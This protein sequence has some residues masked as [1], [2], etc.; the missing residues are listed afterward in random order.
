MSSST[1]SS[2]RRGDPG[3][4]AGSWGDVVGLGFGFAAT[5]AALLAVVVGAFGP[6]LVAAGRDDLRHRRS[7]FLTP[8][9]QRPELPLALFLGDSTL[10]PEWS[11]P[12]DIAR[13]LRG[14]LE[15]QQF[16]W[17]GFEAFQ[18]YLI[19]GR[20]LF[21]EPRAVV[22]TAQHRSFWRDE[23]LWYPDLLGLLPPRELPHALPLP[24]HARGVS[25]PKLMLSSLFGAPG[26]ISEELLELFVGGR[27]E[28]R[29]TPGLRWL[30]PARPPERDL[31]ALVHTRRERFLR[32]AEP[33]FPGHPAVEM[34]GATVELSVRRG[35]QTL[36][37][38]SPIPFEALAAEGLYERERFAQWVD[39][40]R[41]QVEA[42]G[43][44]LLDLH[45][46]LPR[47]DFKDDLGH[48]NRRGALTVSS[49]VQRWLKPVL[50]GDRNALAR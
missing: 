4:P 43:G 25:L 10:L 8:E 11:F 38:V 20:L 16:A 50:E 21:L 36:V 40:L 24:F 28:A 22:I 7:E 45:R 13:Q 39:V 1:S 18:H 46:A 47:A 19:L 37:V 29:R 32:Y 15:V 42:A 2:E 5:V 44:E 35:A 41:E 3:E 9:R 48:Y 12:R 49:H 33:I 14:S 17:Q 31:R 23:P 30:V 34:L 27:I 26:G 6:Q